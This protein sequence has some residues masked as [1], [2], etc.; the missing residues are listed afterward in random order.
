MF[1][2]GVGAGAIVTPE[3]RTPIEIQVEENE[4]HAAGNVEDGQVRVFIKR[5]D[6]LTRQLQES[7]RD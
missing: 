3:Q 2:S 4:S 5:D 1:H 6:S 7:V